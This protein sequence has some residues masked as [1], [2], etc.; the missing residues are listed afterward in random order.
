MKRASRLLGAVLV[1]ASLAYLVFFAV[2]HAQSLPEI[3]WNAR[4]VAGSGA[5]VALYG[6]TLIS[7]ASAWHLLLRSAGERPRLRPVAAIFLLS[8]IGKYLPGNF[9]HYVGRVALAKEQGLGPGPVLLTLAVEAACAILA[10]IAVTAAAFPG[11]QNA[12]GPAGPRHAAAALLAVGGVALASRLVDSPRVRA[13]ARF[14]APA[15]PASRGRRGLL[16]LACL[17]LYAFNFFAFGA[18]AA[19]LAQTVLGA[20]PASW[21]ALAAVMAA[22]WVAGFVTPGAPAGLGIREAILLAGLRPLYGP[23]VALSLPLLFRL[24]TTLGDALGCGAG[25]LLRRRAAGPEEV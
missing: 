21:P 17:G 4:A 19:L 6:L 10:G 25:Y 2:R 16:W 7:S 11:P 13:W 22:A 20:A 18:C 15:P 12:P 8:Q 5:A 3:R 1:A 14:P 23:G 24:V 9:A